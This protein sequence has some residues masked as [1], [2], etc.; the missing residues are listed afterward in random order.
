[1][2]WD[3][4]KYVKKH[5]GCGYS[6]FASCKGRWPHGQQEMIEHIEDCIL[7]QWRLKEH[8]KIESTIKLSPRDEEKIRK[9][10][11][12]LYKEKKR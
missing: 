11:K 3:W 6:V 8:A 4:K 5:V 10:L 2:K 1:M 12:N 7:C 9:E